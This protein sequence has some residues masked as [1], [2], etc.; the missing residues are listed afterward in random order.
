MSDFP[1][2]LSELDIKTIM[3]G[4]AGILK[5]IE[6][7]NYFQ[8]NTTDDVKFHPAGKCT[9]ELI[10]GLYNIG[11]CSRGIFFEKVKFKA[12]DLI[13]FPET[14]S[15]KIINEIQLFWDKGDLYS[16]YGL[17]HKRGILLYG[18]PGTG[19]SCTI[20]LICQDLIKL[21]GIVVKFPDNGPQVLIDAL[22]VLR[23]IQPDVPV[24]VLMEDLDSILDLYDESS[25]L[26]ILDGIEGIH[27]IVFLATTNYPDQLGQRIV[28]RPSRFDR[29]YKMPQPGAESREVYLKHLLQQ[30]NLQAKVNVKKWVSDTE[31]MSIA[32][33]KELFVAVHILGDD[34][35]VALQILNEMQETPDLKEE[36]IGFMTGKYD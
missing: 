12:E 19:K 26:N 34:Y 8:W 17:P 29:R 10:P 25:V 4:A 7:P 23:E 9:N 22:R 18:P 16:K 27:R 1:V 24:I 36:S 28:N 3:R 30:A 13:M 31:D 14:N 32:H 15:E 2:E 6:K 21:G 5:E 11:V 35:E 33:L 20:Q